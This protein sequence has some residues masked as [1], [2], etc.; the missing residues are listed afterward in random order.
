MHYFFI[1]ILYKVAIN[2]THS[3]FEKLIEDFFEKPCYLCGR[4]LTL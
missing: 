1:Y 4:S 2:S 3:D